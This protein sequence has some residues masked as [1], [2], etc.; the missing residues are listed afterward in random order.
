MQ[1][2]SDLPSKVFFCIHEW[3]LYLVCNNNKHLTCVP[4]NDLPVWLCADVVLS[5]Q[6]PRVFD[7]KHSFLSN[8]YSY[9]K[10]LWTDVHSSMDRSHSQKHDFHSPELTQFLPL[11]SAEATTEPEAAGV[12]F[13]GKIC[14]SSWSSI[15]FILERNRLDL[16]LL[17][18]SLT[19]TLRTFLNALY[20]ALVSHSR[21]QLPLQ[22]SRTVERGLWDLL[23][24]NEPHCSKAS[25]GPYKEGRRPTDGSPLESTPCKEGS[26]LA[27][28]VYALNQKLMFGW[29]CF[30]HWQNRGS[31]KQWTKVEM[32]QSDCLKTLFT[33]FWLPV[34]AVI[35]FVVLGGP[36]ASGSQ[37]NSTCKRGKFK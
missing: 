10:G 20:D 27:Y 33:E 16:N 23:L 3:S 11:L 22:W 32:M 28:V 12:P 25:T 7:W 29:C 15:S 4:W 14:Q 8:I 6:G 2:A 18:Q 37:G 17:P 34:P 21:K 35:N 24:Y 31:G 19:L 1:A 30:F 9:S 13:L 26:H 36:A 5:N